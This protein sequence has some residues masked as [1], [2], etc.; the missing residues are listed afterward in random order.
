MARRYKVYAAETGRS[1]QYFFAYSG[2]VH[3]PEGAGEGSDF[4]FVVTADQEPP[5]ILRVFI[6]NRGLAAWHGAHGRELD[7]NELYAAAKM[8]LFRAFDEVERLREEWLGLSVD[9]SNIEE[10][11]DPLGL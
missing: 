7:N 6:S 10:L 2:R 8:C 11:L 3:R 4:V 9:E 5:F 1:Y